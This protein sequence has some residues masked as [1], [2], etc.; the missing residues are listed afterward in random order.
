[1]LQTTLNC[2]LLNHELGLELRWT[3]SDD[4]IILQLVANT[5]SDRY[6]ALGIREISG[7]KAVSGDVLVGWISSKSG[8]GGIDDYF[9]AGDAIQC[10]D[11]AESCPDRSK[12]LLFS[13][14]NYKTYVKSFSRI[15]FVKIDFT[16]KIIHIIHL[17]L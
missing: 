1:M 3:L 13:K 9:L 5:G 8:K 2:E 6:L 4:D 12:V 16:E 15:F 14:I 7:L 10:D 17:F 11:G